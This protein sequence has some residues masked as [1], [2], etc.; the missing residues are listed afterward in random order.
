[1]KIMYIQRHN[2]KRLI[3]ILIHIQHI[4][5]IIIQ[6]LTLWKKMFTITC[7]YKNLL[8]QCEIWKWMQINEKIFYLWSLN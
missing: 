4:F 1:M 8:K 5:E 6:K 3:Y 2:N 7:I